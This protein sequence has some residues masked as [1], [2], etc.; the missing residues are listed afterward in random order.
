ME[1]LGINSRVFRQRR[2]FGNRKTPRT[3]PRSARASRA[4]LFSP[5]RQVADRKSTRLNSSHLGIS[6]A[7]FCLK[8]KKHTRHENVDQSRSDRP[9]GAAGVFN[10]QQSKAAVLK[11]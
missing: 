8:K 11:K 7:V 2:P 9:V 6:Y 5:C 1:S 3:C 10:G 4:G